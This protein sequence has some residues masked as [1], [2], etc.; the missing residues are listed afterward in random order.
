MKLRTSLECERWLAEHGLPLDL[1]GGNRRSAQRMGVRVPG[2]AGRKTAIARELAAK[3]LTSSSSVIFVVVG[4][5]I[6]PSSEHPDLFL[7]YRASFGDTRPLHEAPCHE[8]NSDEVSTLASLFA[9]SLYFS[10]DAVIVAGDGSVVRTTNDELLTVESD[11]D[12]IEQMKQV[13]ERLGL[14]VSTDL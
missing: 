14:G 5:G 2:D 7:R 9:M 4:H 10:W 8:L 13:L 12:V 11:P 3:L 1:D 6:W